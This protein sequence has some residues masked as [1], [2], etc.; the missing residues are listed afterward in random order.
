MIGGSGLGVAEEP[1][2]IHVD[3]LPPKLEAR[4]L[5]GS[6]KEYGSLILV[7]R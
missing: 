1:P 7:L 6:R 4:F 5:V 3:L 2:I